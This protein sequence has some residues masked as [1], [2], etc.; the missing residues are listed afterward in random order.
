MFH[1]RRSFTSLLG[2]HV[3]LLV[4]LVVVEFAISATT[5]LVYDTVINFADEVEYIWW[6]VVPLKIAMRRPIF[7]IHGSRRG[8][9][10]KFVYV[11]LRHITYLITASIVALS[12]F[13]VQGKTWDSRQCIG[14]TLLQL[15][16]NQVITIVVEGILVFRI[17]AMYNRN[18]W[19]LIVISIL[20]AGVAVTMAV[21]CFL[22]VPNAKWTPQCLVTDVPPIYGSYWCYIS[23]QNLGQYSILFSLM[24]DGTWAY[25]M[26]FG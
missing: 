6:S 13:G 11:F 26:M 10:M 7:D 20:Y 25:V 9:W 2:L 16:S 19:I 4:L 8:L 24:R 3:F 22:S 23:S 5:F 15:V 18:K 12:I 21:A 14:W 1:D 17:C